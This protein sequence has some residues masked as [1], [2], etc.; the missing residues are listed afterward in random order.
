[1]HALL[2]IHFAKGKDFDQERN[3]RSWIPPFFHTKYLRSSKFGEI[4]C[5]TKSL[6]TKLKVN[7]QLMKTNL[8]QKCF[9]QRKVGYIIILHIAKKS[10]FCR[11]YYRTPINY[12]YDAINCF[13]QHIH[14][15]GWITNESTNRFCKWIGGRFPLWFIR[16][17]ISCAKSL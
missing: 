5:P 2:S 13:Y 7:G 17:V 6:M 14:I 11:N 4:R 9:L 10:F 12:H 16:I 15:I 1:M 3:E 8:N